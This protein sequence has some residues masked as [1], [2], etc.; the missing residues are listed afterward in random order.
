MTYSKIRIEA[1]SY[2]QLRCPSCP[3]TTGE[4]DAAV[5]KGFLAYKNFKRLIDDNPEIKTV[6]L[7]NFGEIFI[8]P[9]IVDIIQYAHY[10]G[11][12]LTAKNGVNFNNVK[13]ETI[14]SLVK[15]Q[16]KA[17][18]LS[19]DGITQETYSRYR[20]RGNYDTVISNVKK[21][22]EFKKQYNSKW[23]K[24]TWQ[25]IVFGHNEH[26]IPAAREL[27]DKL[28]IKFFLKLSWDD[29]ISPLKDPDYVRKEVGIGA[30]TRDEFE[31]NNGI[32]YKVKVCKQLWESPMINWNGD[33]L[34]CCINYWGTFGGN[35]FV[36]GLIPS[37]K[38][39]SM[40]YAKAMLQGKKQ[41]R[42]DIPCSSC[43][44]YK[45]MKSNNLYLDLSSDE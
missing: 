30:A 12:D 33:I 19:I 42:A 6:E 10:K 15:Y 39:E 3:T 13:E 23:P 27:A 29:E 43:A 34:G 36:D 37:L 14:E 8:N 41:A 45:T 44:V 24:L 20:K 18:T 31:H 9:Q 17:M 32:N 26:E 22:V 5:G 25:F 28:G 1:S 16:F 21:L 40:S 4:I 2:C 11:V 35:A 38:S 7:S